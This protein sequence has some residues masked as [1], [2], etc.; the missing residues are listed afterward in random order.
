MNASMHSCIPI[1]IYSFLYSY[2]SISFIHFYHDLAIHVLSIFLSCILLLIHIF[3]YVPI[4]H[5][6]LLIL[7]VCHRLL[8][9]SFLSF[10]P[11][12]HVFLACSIL[13]LSV[14]LSFVYS[15][16]SYL[17]TCTYHILYVAQTCSFSFTFMFMFIFM[18]IF[19]FVFMFHIL[20]MF[21]WTHLY[22]LHFL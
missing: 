4:S 17:M 10:M 2:L 21:S 18:F 8:S 3:V 19:H 14:C 12:Y 7:V 16:L 9:L 6:H 5:V 22:T 13:F 1:F 15:R 11:F 20:F